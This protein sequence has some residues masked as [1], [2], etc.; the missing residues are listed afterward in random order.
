MIRLKAQSE[1]LN[2]MK[3]IVVVGIDIFEIIPV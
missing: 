3:G 1:A 2:K